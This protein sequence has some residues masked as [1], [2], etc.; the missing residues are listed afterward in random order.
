MLKYALLVFFVGALGGLDLH[1]SDR[2]QHGR[3]R[4][5]RGVERGNVLDRHAESSRSATSAPSA[6]GR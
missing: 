5:E 1:E 4:V 2:D 3:Q 6:S